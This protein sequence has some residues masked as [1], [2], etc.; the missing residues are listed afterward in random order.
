[1]LGG[2]LVASNWIGAL[3]LELSSLLMSS[4]GGSHKLVQKHDAPQISASANLPLSF[5]V[6]Q[7]FS[8]TAPQLLS[9]SAPRLLSSSAPR[10]FG[11]SALQLLST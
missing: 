11:P 3:G 1:M 9:S 6:Q 8:S 4:L 5:P 7:L 10:T 2:L